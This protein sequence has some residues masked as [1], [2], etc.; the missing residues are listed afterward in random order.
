MWFQVRPGWAL[1]TVVAMAAEADMSSALSGERLTQSAISQRISLF[2][3][4][5]DTIGYLVLA[6]RLR[7]SSLARSIPV[8]RLQIPISMK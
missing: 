4:G 6:I 1:Y 2:F 8:N 7:T 3:T 5:L